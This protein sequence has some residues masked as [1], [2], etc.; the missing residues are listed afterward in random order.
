MTAKGIRELAKSASIRSIAL[1]DVLVDEE[2]LHAI[3]AIEALENIALRRT[4]VTDVTCTHLL[5][6]KKLKTVDLR[7]TCVTIDGKR[8][9]YR[10]GL[11]VGI[12][13]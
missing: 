4:A 12:G 8:A 11:N 7:E 10:R 5:N 13:E 9:L 1:N 6:C 3:V 2:F